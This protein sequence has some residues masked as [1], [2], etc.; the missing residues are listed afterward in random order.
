MMGR[1]PKPTAQKAA[2]GN[3]GKRPLNKSELNQEVKAP[4]KPADLSPHAKKLWPQFVRLFKKRGILRE[5]DGPQLAILVEAISMLREARAALNKLPPDTRL[6][7]KAGAGVQV[8]PLLYIIRDQIRAINRI[9]AEFGLSPAAR[10]RIQYDDGP[11][12]PTSGAADLDAILA[13]ADEPEPQFRV[14]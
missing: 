8:N 14:Q 3:P 9:G 12:T 10:T 2:A 4:T 7:I 1:P 6:L 11:G 13:G 5:E